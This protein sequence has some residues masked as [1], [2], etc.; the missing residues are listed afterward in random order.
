M[1]LIIYSWKLDL[2]FGKVHQL[3]QALREGDCL[4]RAELVRGSQ[5]LMPLLHLD[6]QEAAEWTLEEDQVRTVEGCVVGEAAGLVD[7]GRRERLHPNA[8]SV[9]L[10]LALLYLRQHLAYV[11]SNLRPISQLPQPQ[12]LIDV[13]GQYSF[14]QAV[15]N[16]VEVTAQLLRV[17]LVH[18]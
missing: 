2:T 12:I 11:T 15:L 1:L 13:Q 16:F 7:V 14:G 8:V 3:E 6:E 9:L 5:L 17:P 18:V 10:H 4:D